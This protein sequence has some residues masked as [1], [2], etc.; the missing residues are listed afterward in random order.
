MRNL[1]IWE[2]A[3]DGDEIDDDDV[4]ENLLSFLRKFIRNAGY[5][6]PY[7]SYSDD[8]IIVQFILEKTETMPSVMRVMGLLNKLHTDILIEYKCEFE[9][10]ETQDDRP[11]FN[12][13][14]SYGEDEDE[15]KPF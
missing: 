10:V 8:A 7:V 12:A 9:V 15:T 14:F 11:L 6:T 2:A 1:M 13:Y 4:I 5:E 3:Q